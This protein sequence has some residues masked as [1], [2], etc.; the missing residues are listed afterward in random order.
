MSPLLLIFK[1]F[2]YQ[3][4]SW[5]MARGVV[6]KVEFHCGELF[7]WR[8][9]IPCNEGAAK[10]AR[11]IADSLVERKGF[12]PSVPVH[13]CFALTGPEVAGFFAPN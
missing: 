2:L 13:L 4:A 1:S 11:R 10:W 7:P 6:A 5:T 3:A 8:K 12:E 9:A